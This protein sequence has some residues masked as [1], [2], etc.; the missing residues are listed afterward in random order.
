[1]TENYALRRDSIKVD[2]TE[3][4]ASSSVR[5][6]NRRP[7]DDAEQPAGDGEDQGTDETEHARIRSGQDFCNALCQ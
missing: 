6:P 2:P 3:F 5:A 1:M 7:P 4:C